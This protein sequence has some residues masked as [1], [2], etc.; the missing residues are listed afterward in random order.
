MEAYMNKSACLNAL[1]CSSCKC[2][3]IVLVICN[4]VFWGGINWCLNASVKTKLAPQ[5]CVLVQTQY[6]SLAVK[7]SALVRVIIA[8]DRQSG[9][10][11]R[12]TYP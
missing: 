4:K 9:Q 3:I 11:T 2:L 12:I 5:D 8:L 10:I 6:K 7:L 1:P